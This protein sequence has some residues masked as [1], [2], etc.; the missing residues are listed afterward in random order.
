MGR[1]TDKR[2]WE[3]S[4][5]LEGW[6]ILPTDVA[7]SFDDRIEKVSIERGKRVRVTVEVLEDEDNGGRN[8]ENG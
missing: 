1:P 5:G 8:V 2:V 7:M 6:F 4:H 3:G